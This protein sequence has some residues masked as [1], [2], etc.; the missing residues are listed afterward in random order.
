MSNNYIKIPSI[1]GV[2]FSD[3]QDVQLTAFVGGIEHGKS[4][5]L[6]I[7]SCYCCLSEKNVKLLMEA[8]NARLVGDI[9]A[10]GDEKFTPNL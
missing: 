3:A 8:L 7:G 6:S 1:R 2:S 9:T 4:V 10:T 5:Q